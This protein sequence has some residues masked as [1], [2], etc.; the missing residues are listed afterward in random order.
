MGFGNSRSQGVKTFRCKTANP[1]SNLR[2]S[3]GLIDVR[4][5]SFS[6]CFFLSVCPFADFP[7]LS[8]P[9]HQSGICAV[10]CQRLLSCGTCWILCRHDVWTRDLPGRECVLTGL[11]RNRNP[12]G[13][14]SLNNNP[15]STL[16][17][18]F[19][20]SCMGME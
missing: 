1:R 3:L 11:C 7:G 12:G 9:W 14:K 2:P 6:V 10:D 19:T 13:E 18:S 4:N 17:K 20:A 16:I 8:L 5:S 15:R